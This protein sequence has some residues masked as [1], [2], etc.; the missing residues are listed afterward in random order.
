MLEKVIPYN[1]W[2]FLRNLGDRFAANVIDYVS[3]ALP[4]LSRKEEQHVLSVGSILFM[5]GPNSHLW[6]IGCLSSSLPDFTVDS[7]NIHALRGRHTADLLTKAGYALQDIPFGDPGILAAEVIAKQCDQSAKQAHT[8]IAIIPHYSN[9]DSYKTHYGASREVNIIDMGTDRIDVISEIASA[10]IVISESLHGLI[11]GCAL[12]KRITWIGN[13]NA[14]KFKYYDWMTTIDTNLDMLSPDINSLEQ[15]VEEARVAKSIVDKQA[16]IDAFP[17]HLAYYRT[18]RGHVNYRNA[19]SHEYVLF[20]VTREQLGLGQDKVLEPRVFFHAAR[21][22]CDKMFATWDE[23]IY[24][25]VSLCGE[26]VVPQRE[27]MREILFEMDHHSHAF[28]VITTRNEIDGLNRPRSSCGA[29]L[30]YASGVIPEASA[31]LVRPQDKWGWEDYYVIF[32][33]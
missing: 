25:L 9:Y 28:A 6:G 7:R 15:L 19:R 31:L 26:G 23:P 22:Y 17:S 13:P 5:A 10:D 14:D 21:R 8:E 12:G 2:T 27:Q 20:I 33:V 4:V 16:L 30:D 3:D 1:G 18:S 32:C 29:H 11:F 24:A